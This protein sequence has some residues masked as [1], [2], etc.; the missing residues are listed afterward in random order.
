VREGQVGRRQSAGIDL[1]RQQEAPQDLQLLALVV[2]RHGRDL[3]AVAQ[4]GGDGVDQVGR[5]DEQHLR[6]VEGH[7]EVVV[8]KRAVLLGIEHLEQRRGRVAPP[9]AA[10]EL[11]ELVQHD[12]RGSWRRPLEARDDAPGIA[13]T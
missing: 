4:R 7:V 11:V 13:P 8:R 3:H 12:A 9:L 2:A 5:G 1:P 10:A 6:Q